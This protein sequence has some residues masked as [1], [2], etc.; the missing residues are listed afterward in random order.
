[1]DMDVSAENKQLR[2][3]LT[4]ATVGGIVL[5]L[6]LWLRQLPADDPTVLLPAEGSRATSTVG[7]VATTAPRIAVDVVGAVVRPGVYYFDQGARVDDAIN[8]AGGYAPDANRDA[9]NAAIRS[10]VGNKYASLAWR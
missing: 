8:A 1:M 10:E 6:F 3:L 2:W 4:F 7:D 5:A 9:V